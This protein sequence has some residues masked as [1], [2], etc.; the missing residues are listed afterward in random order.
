MVPKVIR[1]IVQIVAGMAAIVAIGSYSVLK[2]S[3]PDM[4]K[5][6]RLPGYSAPVDVEFDDFGIPRILAES[7]EDAYRALGFV[8]ARERLFQMDLFRRHGAGR[9]A[10]ILG[11]PL[12]DSDRWHRVM[13][14]A[15]VA[16]GILDRLPLDQRALLR[17]YAEGVNQAMS[18]MPILPFECLLLGYRPEP[19]REEDSLLVILGMF[20][21]LTWQI[22]EQERMAT[23][24]ER[25]LGSKVLAFLT[26]DSDRYSSRVSERG[27]GWRPELPI[28]RKEL[29][30]L[31]RGNRSDRHQAG[32]VSIPAVP[33]GS[34]G[35]LVAAG[36]TWDGRAILANDM[37]LELKVPNIWYRAEVHSEGNH[38]AGFTLPGVPLF[39]SGTNRRIG[40]GFTNT[41]GDFVD[42]VVLETEPEN[43]R[44]YR[45]PEGP[46]DFGE[47]KETIR[48]RGMPDVTLSVATTRW[49]PVLPEVL[50]GRSVAVHWTA[51]DPEATDL[52]LLY[53][54]EAEDVS[55]ALAV[56]KRAGG[57]PLNALVA[58]SHGDIG[59]TYTGRIPARSGLDGLT[60]R[61]W[62][63][64][65]RG[66]K[67]YIAPDEIPQRVNPPQGFLVSANQRMLGTAYPHVIGQDFDSGYR[68]WR[69]AE[70]L[71]AMRGITERDLLKLQLDTKT[72]FYRP[73]QRLALAALAETPGA[74]D[75]SDLR[76]NLEA[77]DGY[78]E[79]DSSGLAVL[80]EFRQR[81][82]D[83]VFSPFLARCRQ[84]DPSFEYG[85]RIMDG[86]LLQLLDAKD[87]ELLPDPERYRDWNALVFTQLKEAATAVAARCRIDS[88]GESKWGCVNNSGIK[89]PFSAFASWLGWLIDMPDEAVP[90]C[91]HCVR[92]AA[93]G[94]GASERLVVAPGREDN[95]LFHMPA[96]QSGNPLSPF[97]RD[98]QPHWVRG[99]ALA[100]LAGEARHRLRLE[101]ALPAE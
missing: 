22:G 42:F 71:E 88:P 37:H 78:A 75:S 19:W 45:T 62:A 35:W 36:K 44:A 48:V 12:L 82:A 87:P 31:L 29:A 97:Y 26:P 47:R 76:R 94:G 64:G 27:P 54:S 89:H 83:A 81:L 2:I 33:T 11:P 50:P 1:R 93:P 28:P 60:S 55:E 95:A 91:R 17:A 40:W 3:V 66:W 21:N 70:Q 49:G 14:F 7:G 8:A 96:G 6:Y 92:L 9:L 24:M 53:L 41:A 51:L 39:I 4:D 79:V 69:I 52:G 99:T 67:G 46:M 10:E 59:W 80:V 13:G 34:N 61:S 63:D 18:E 23:V 84:L 57:P 98:Q 56:L 65:S 20:E 30:E 43:P 101:P 73:Y 68:A 86:P 32:L 72:D 16:A 15:Q 100:L 38:V 77:W 5:T 25:V 74:V 58:D 90:G 85:W